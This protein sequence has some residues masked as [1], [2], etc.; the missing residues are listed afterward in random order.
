[1]GAVMSVVRAALSPLNQAQ[2]IIVGAIAVMLLVLVAVAGFT[3]TA[4][5]SASADTA[6]AAPTFTLAERAYLADLHQHVPFSADA[7]MVSLGHDICTDLE[8][9]SEA[10]LRASIASTGTY[11]TGSANWQIYYAE[12]DLCGT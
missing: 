7:D 6:T 2:K 9:H 5:A 12:R 4:S 11:S 10:W 8:T 3:S 1:M